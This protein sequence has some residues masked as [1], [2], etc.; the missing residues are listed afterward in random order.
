MTQDE[1]MEMAREAC[2]FYMDYIR[3][4][5][6]KQL[7]DFA[8]LVAAK[9]REALAQPEQEPV[10]WMWD[11]NNGAGYSSRGIGFYQTDIPFAKH[12]PLYTAPPQRTWVGLT[13]EEIIGLTCECID[14]GEFNMD[15]AIDFARAIEAKLK[16]KNT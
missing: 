3:V 15:C 9:E 16:Q 10:A 4:D 6:M 5:S 2:L 1:V 8:N 7:E 13:D 14:E 11:I 12:T